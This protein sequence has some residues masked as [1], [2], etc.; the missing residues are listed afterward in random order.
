M[1]YSCSF[2]HIDDLEFKP[3]IGVA[4][5]QHATQKSCKHATDEKESE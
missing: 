2:M 3:D 4:S 1:A 5:Q